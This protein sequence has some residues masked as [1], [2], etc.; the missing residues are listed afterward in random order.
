MAVRLSCPS[1]NTGFTLPQLP[2]DRR[3]ACPR[4]GDVFPVRGPESGDGS[5][6]AEGSGP[7]ADSASGAPPPATHPPRARRA[8]GK[9]SVTRS[10]V[11]AL[12]LGLLGLGAGLWVYHTRGVPRPGGEPEPRPAG[13]VVPATQLRG[14]GYLPADTNIAFA[15]QPGP[16]L[17]YAVRTNQDPRELLTK[18]GIPARV[19]D[20]VTNLGLTLPQIDHVAGGAYLPNGKWGEVRFTLVLVLHRPPADEDEFLARLKARKQPGG[21]ER[22][23]ADLFRLPMTLA[24]VSP[25]VWV[26]GYS[27]KDLEAV[28]RGG[29]GAGGKHFPAGLAEM[30]SQRVPPDAAAWLATDD[31]RWADKDAVQAIVALVKR[32]EWLA[33][34]ARGRAGA[35][36]LSFGEEP[37]VRLFV[38]AADEATG[39]QVRDYFRER[40]ASDEKVRHGGGGELA[41]FDAPIDPAAAFATLQRFLG[42][43]GKK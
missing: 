36:A 3:A 23:D 13:E 33:V 31:G 8:A 41:F 21:K 6:E 43:A 32:P 14:L 2:A 35:A 37:R 40:A 26:F 42:D 25:T 12:S 10:V 22:Y 27:A 7:P 4:C 18:A 34:L 15:A 19:L 29:Y 16:A 39:Q 28:D 5:P 38:R 24:R 20:G 17:A 1:C 30:I 9:W 11:V